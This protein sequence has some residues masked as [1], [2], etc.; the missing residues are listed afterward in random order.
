MRD[1]VVRQIVLK[2][3]HER[4]QPERQRI[5]CLRSQDRS[6]EGRPPS[7]K[8][9]AHVEHEH[10]GLRDPLHDRRVD[11]R[12]D[13]PGHDRRQHEHNGLGRLTADDERR[14]RAQVL[15]GDRD[16]LEKRSDRP[17]EDHHADPRRVRDE[18]VAVEQRHEETR[19]QPQHHARKPANGRVHE[20][21][22]QHDRSVAVV[23]ARQEVERAHAEAE[24][25]DRGRGADDEE[26][27]FVQAELGQR[28]RSHQ[29]ERQRQ[30]QTEP[31]GL[32][33]EQ[34]EGMYRQ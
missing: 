32:R 18:R 13:G 12:S 19:P 34:P 25:Q 15:T 33:D 2:L 17:R 29:H 27:L 5:G 24:R 16:D 26:R 14:R 10:Q 30:R 28:Q 20:E 31:D 3:Q 1:Y 9:R 6:A 7:R 23:V 21:D 8:T 11:E 4:R 22:V